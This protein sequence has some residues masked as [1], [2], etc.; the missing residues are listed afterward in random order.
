MRRIGAATGQAATR[1]LAL[2]PMAAATP[3]RDNSC[4]GQELRRAPGAKRSALG[5]GRYVVAF[6]VAAPRAQ[7]LRR[8]LDGRGAAARARAEHAGDH[9]RQ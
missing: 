8:R 7:D 3:D 4:T 2:A 9:F 6:G 5:D 1:L